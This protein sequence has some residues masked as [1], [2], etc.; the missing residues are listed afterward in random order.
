MQM[1]K[2]KFISCFHTVWYRE[3]KSAQLPFMTQIHRNNQWT[4]VKEIKDYAILNEATV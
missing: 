1:N 4:D 3:R 2:N